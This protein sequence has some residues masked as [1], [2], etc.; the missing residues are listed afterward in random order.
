[1]PSTSYGLSC[2]V[3]NCCVDCHSAGF[4]IGQL[5]RSAESRDDA[6]S[7]TNVPSQGRPGRMF[8]LTQ[9]SYTREKGTF[10]AAEL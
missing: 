10:T 2:L 1:M 4:M 8:P 7:I 6:A 5:S 3:G 9:I